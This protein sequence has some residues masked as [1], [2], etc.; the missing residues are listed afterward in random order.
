MA[1]GQIKVDTITFT[2]GG[3]D[4]SVSISGLVQNPTFSGN[5]TVTGT[6]SGNTLQGQT[7]SGV[8]VTGTTA[9]FASGTFTSLTGTTTTGTTASFATGVFTSITGTTATITS[10]IFASG[11]AAAPSVSVGTTDN[12][13]YSPGADQLAFST[14]GAGRLFI[15]ASGNVGVG[16]TP[17][18]YKLDVFGAARLNDSL[19][20]SLYLEEPGANSVRIKAGTSASFIGTTSNHPFYF[21]TNNTERM[22]LDSSGRL[23]LG[24]SSPDSTLTVGTLSGGA[25]TVRGDIII[26]HVG[27][28]ASLTT[29]GGLEFKVDG[30]NSGYGARLLSAFNGVSAYD[31]AIQT[32]NN[33]TSWSTSFLIDSSGRLLVGT[34]SDSGGA[35]LQVNDNRIR[36]ATAKTPSSASDTGT[37]GEICWDSSYIYVCT[38]TDTWKRAALSTW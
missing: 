33:S 19:D 29:K 34:S 37:A 26:N 12:G 15:D 32:R 28:G 7:V 20:A 2:D 4:K 10:G 38:A 17:S 5:I 18:S 31:F 11:T 1:Y 24:T 13:L 6:I 9:Q 27:G 36:I 14:N 30:N 21:Q 16:A 25:P 23:G 35:L 22:R 8:T 3:I